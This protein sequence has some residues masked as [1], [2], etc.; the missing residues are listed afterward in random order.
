M[1]PTVFKLTN[2]KN[3][4]AKL[5]FSIQKRR[6]TDDTKKKNKQNAADE[7]IIVTSKSANLYWINL[8]VFDFKGTLRQGKLL[9]VMTRTVHL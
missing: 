8:T 5:C 3:R 4:N 9:A 7:Q 6:K 1:D 2:H